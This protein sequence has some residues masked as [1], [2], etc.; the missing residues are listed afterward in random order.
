MEIRENLIVLAA[1]FFISGANPVKANLDFDRNSD[2]T[3]FIEQ[4]KTE[5]SAGRPLPEA[6]EPAVERT[7][8][9]LEGKNREAR[10]AVLQAQL[11][12][13]RLPYTL[14][15]FAFSVTTE[16]KDGKPS[17]REIKGT[18]VV[19]TINPGKPE[20]VLGAHYDPVELAGGAYSPAVVDN[21][22]GVGIALE[23]AKAFMPASL[24]NR[25][26]RV[27]FFDHEEIGVIG[28]AIYALGHTRL[29]GNRI[30]A[31]MSL[32]VDAYGDTL[33]VGSINEL[34]K[35]LQKI[36]TDIASERGYNIL[37]AEQYP[38]SD[39]RSFQDAKI[40]SLNISSLGKEE[41]R[42]V[43]ELWTK[44]PNMTPQER[45]QVFSNH[46]ALPKVFN[47]T[48]SAADTSQNVEPASMER[49]FNFM[50]EVIEKMDYN[51][52]QPAV[53]PLKLRKLG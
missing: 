23:L 17:V 3:A 8:G 25:T 41:A 37:L 27:V 35:G 43:A 2:I 18:N 12:A 50:K 42:Q 53:Q 11:E 34:N 7:V 29:A 46:S 30:T 26:L 9:A 4:A 20:I 40:P 15:P 5:A 22:A 13:A 38:A 28:S 47:V 24:Q 51:A 19:V 14:E 31:M 44:L 16:D 36:M 32:D 10:L 21:G 33:F 45:R 39:N 52:G 48:H 49:V 1:V 6:A